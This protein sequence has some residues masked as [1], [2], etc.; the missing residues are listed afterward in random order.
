M[1]PPPDVAGVAGG[2]PIPVFSDAGPAPGGIQVASCAGNMGGHAALDMPGL[3]LACRARDLAHAI[4]L[5]VSKVRR[6][7]ER[8]IFRQVALEIEGLPD[9]KPVGAF[10]LTRLLRLRTIKLNA[11][12]SLKAAIVLLSG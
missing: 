10:E 1:Q 6:P 12:R 8:Q 2:D 7:V 4:G 5:P 11:N 3:P 9:P